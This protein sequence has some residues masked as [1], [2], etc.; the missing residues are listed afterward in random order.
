[1]KFSTYILDNLDAIVREWETFART[2]LPSAN[3]M[4][5]L[6][7]RD[8]SREI[9]IAI[10]KDMETAQSQAE[11]AAKSKT[12]PAI[13]APE[14]IAA[15]HG[16]LRQLAG[17][18]LA[19][20]VSEFRAMRASVLALWRGVE[21][22]GGL[23][24]AIDE[25]ARFNEAI[26]QAL[27]ESIQRYS[28]D[29]AMFLAVVGHELR[30]PLW[31]IQGSSEVLARSNAPEITKQNATRRIWRASKMMAHLV[32][33]LLEFT[34]TRLGHGTPIERSDCNMTKACRD[35]VETVRSIHPKQRFEQQISG[36][37]HIQAD[38]PRVQQ[39]L[40][41]LL[42]NAV[43]HGDPRSSVVLSAVS[44][45]D[46]VVVKI[47]N[48][49]M[50]IPPDALESIF[51]PMIQAPAALIEPK[52]HQF[53]SMGL[54]LHIVREIVRGHDG[55]VTVQSAEDTGTVVTLRWPIAA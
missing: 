37:L 54:G 41:N 49:G 50:P 4:S 34:R 17:F 38:C 32:T 39:V 23:A 46:A 16:A 45:D 22:E 15:A 21:P 5:G 24:P 40:S 18:D 1:M 8:H 53:T 29:V 33:D 28:S 35:A 43:H 44:E 55:T 10:A 47:I 6:A 52:K 36:D 13:D 7:L 30:T 27:A 11:R 3:S 12:L 14:T 48:F 2:L 9:L 25:I 20:V 31:T 51:E 42:N 19:Q 26:D